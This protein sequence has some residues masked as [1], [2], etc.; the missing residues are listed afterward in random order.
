[1]IKSM[2]RTRSVCTTS[3]K[4]ERL[5]GAFIGGVVGLFGG[6]PGLL[7]TKKFCSMED[8]DLST[9]I[10]KSTLMDGIIAYLTAGLI[11]LPA[12]IALAPVTIPVGTVLISKQVVKQCCCHGDLDPESDDDIS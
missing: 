9:L 12:S 6:I 3:K 10:Y 11:F 2:E 1:M 8:S 4:K 5:D 7:L